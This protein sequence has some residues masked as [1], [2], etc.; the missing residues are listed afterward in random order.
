M[1]RGESQRLVEYRSVPCSTE[2]RTAE[3]G[4][5]GVEFMTVCQIVI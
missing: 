3:I 4:E 2:S 5:L 1:G